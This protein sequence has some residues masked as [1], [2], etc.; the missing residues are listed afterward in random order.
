MDPNEK[1]VIEFQALKRDPTRPQTDEVISVKFREGISTKGNRTIRADWRTPYRHFSTWH[2]PDA[3][4]TKGMRDW[5]L[6]YN[7]TNGATVTPFTVS[8]VKDGGFFRI[9]GYNRPADAEPI[10]DKAA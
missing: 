9:L 4:H 3:K 1:L 10:K 8:Y 7:A 5:A 6:F 2:M